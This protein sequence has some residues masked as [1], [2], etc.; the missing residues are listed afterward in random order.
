MAT[1]DRALTR[2]AS[3]PAIR[4]RH[5]GH[6][7]LHLAL[8]RVGDR[9]SLLVVQALLAGARRF[10]DLQAELGG[11]APNVL[12]TRLRQLEGDGLV[13]ATP[14]SERPVRYAY[15]LT[16]DGAALAGALRLLATWG[17]DQ[18]GAP[19]EAEPV[20]HEACGT[21]A[22]PRWWCPTCERGLDDDELDDL[23]WI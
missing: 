13:V 3:R 15:E 20:V 9:W 7:G 8:G 1:H 17:A 23:R 5:A 14:Y 12:A 21:A 16:A 10:N 18:A 2:R 22:E 19:A 4:D 6:A 11:I